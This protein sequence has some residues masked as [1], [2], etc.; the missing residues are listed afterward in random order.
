MRHARRRKHRVVKLLI[1]PAPPTGPGP[2]TVS[3]QVAPRHK[4]PVTPR[5]TPA[6]ANPQPITIRLQ[7]RSSQS[8]RRLSASD[9]PGSTADRT[10]HGEAGMLCS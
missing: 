4:M 6:A 2:A 3:G 9:V 7:R 1:R 5:V 10:T 8:L